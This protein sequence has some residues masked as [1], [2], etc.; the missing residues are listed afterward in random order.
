V[1][2]QLCLLP[3]CRVHRTEPCQASDQKKNTLPKRRKPAAEQRTSDHPPDRD[4]VVDADDSNAGKPKIK[5]KDIQGLKYLDMVAPLLERLH[6]DKGD[7]DKAANRELHYEKLY[8]LV[9]L[10]LFNPTVTA[11]RSIPRPPN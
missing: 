7:R 10:Y 2:R 8:M 5:A 11:L 3:S 9:L 1:S 6:L 4:E